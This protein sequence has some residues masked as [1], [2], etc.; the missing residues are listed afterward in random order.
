MHKGLQLDTVPDG[1]F[2]CPDPLQAHL[3][4]QNHPLTSELPVQLRGFR[5]HGIRL[6]ADM[7]R[8]L[9]HFFAQD[10][11]RAGVRHDGGVNANLRGQ[12]RGSSEIIQFVVEWIAVHGHI[13]L[14]SSTVGQRNRFPQFL[15]IKIPGKGP[16]AE[17]LHPSVDRIRTEVQCR[18]KRVHVSGRRK[19]FGDPHQRIPLSS[20]YFCQ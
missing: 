14:F 4:G 18:P 12:S 10:H 11:N 19:Q 1:F 3:P 17:T 2:E 6:G 8:K 7:N 16:Q 5:V 9:R 20:S 13:E 15:R